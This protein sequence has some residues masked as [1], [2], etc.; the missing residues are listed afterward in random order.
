M[1]LIE[2][3][4]VIDA[5][6]ERV[7]DLSL[8]IDLHMDSVKDT[9]EVA[10]GGTIKGLIGL[11]QEV[12]FKAKHFGLWFQLTSRIVAFDRPN[13]FRDSQVAGPFKRFDHDHVF[14]AKNGTTIMTDRF[15]YSA[16]LGILGRCADVLVLTR[17]MRR[18]LSQRNQFIKL[19]AETE[20]WRNFLAT[21]S[22]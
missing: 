19:T 1:P 4:T 11:G 2:L 15:D 8:S 14:A 6:L 22:G 12:T 7:F 5:P 18:M 17:H 21:P 20:A 10:V 13:Y 9:G 16:P 3:Q